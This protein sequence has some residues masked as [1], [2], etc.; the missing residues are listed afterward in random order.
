[1]S[2]ASIY[3]EECEQAGVVAH[4]DQLIKKGNTPQ[5]AA[6]IAMR[7][8]PGTKGTDRALLEGDIIHHGLQHY[9]DWF[10]EMAI[11]RARKAGI[12]V[13]GKVYKSGLA[14]SRGPECPDAWV[15]GTDDILRV[16]KKRNLSCRGIVNYTGHDTPPTPD[17]PLAEDLIQESIPDMLMQEPKLAKDPVQLREAIIEKHGAPAAKRAPRKTKTPGGGPAG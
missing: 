4:Y 14:D 16:C 5:F 12:D 8:P 13:A 3:R 2:L 6:M 10:K 15:G 9:P 7:Q 1:M 11:G 17:V